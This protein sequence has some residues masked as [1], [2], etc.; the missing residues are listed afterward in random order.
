M[1]IKITELTPASTL[2]G[3][4]LTPLIQ[5][6]ETRQIAVSSVFTALTSQNDG[7]YVCGISVP[8]Q[9]Y[10][11]FTGAGNCSSLDLGLHTCSNVNFAGLSAAGDTRVCGSLT[12]A[13]GGANY[14]HTN[15][16]L[17]AYGGVD[18]CSDLNVRGNTILGD[19][20]DDTITIGGCTVEMSNLPEKEDNSVIIR[21]SDNTLGTDEIDSKVWG[22]KLVAYCGTSVGN[23]KVPKF[24]GTDGT[25]QDSII[26][27]SGTAVIVNGDLTVCGSGI[28]G[29]TTI[30][31]NVNIAGAKSLTITGN[32]TVGGSLTL[33]CLPT[34]DPLVSGGI[35]HSGGLLRISCCT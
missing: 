11:A 20:A 21:D 1:G 5:S 12:V 2:V 17:S 13:G 10:L 18:I 35:W 23:N 15:V 3:N 29:V 25:V 32:L 8:S 14:I 19:A 33:Q 7:R 26:S 30:S 6:T 31:N 28:C 9:G 24:I 27:E 16:P 34:S 22:G 4:E